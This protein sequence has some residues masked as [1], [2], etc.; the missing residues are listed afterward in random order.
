LQLGQHIRDGECHRSRSD[1]KGTLRLCDVVGVGVLDGVRD[2]DAVHDFEDV[3]KATKVV[4]FDDEVLALLVSESVAC[5][6]TC[7]AGETTC[8]SDGVANS[9]RSL[10]APSDSK[11]HV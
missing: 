4:D 5:N 11:Q 3:L 9:K 10:L 6:D 8:V 1:I 2:S 7:A